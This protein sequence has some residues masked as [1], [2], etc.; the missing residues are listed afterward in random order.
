M[1]LTHPKPHVENAT[2]SS[3]G[4]SPGPDG[5][6]AVTCGS[7]LPTRPKATYNN[8]FTRRITAKASAT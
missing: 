7:N 6:A 1:D 4:G 8:S 2:A 3:A 5:E